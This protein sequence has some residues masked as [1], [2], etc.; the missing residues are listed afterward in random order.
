MPSSERGLPSEGETEAQTDTGLPQ[1]IQ[2]EHGSLGFALRPGCTKKRLGWQL[3]NLQTGPGPTGA[4][5]GSRTLPEV[6]LLGTDDVTR[7]KAKITE[8]Q[9]LVL[10]PVHAGGWVCS[11]PLCSCLLCV[12]ARTPMHA[13]TPHA[14]PMCMHFPCTCNSVGVPVSECGWHPA[15]VGAGMWVLGEAV[16]A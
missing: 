5:G 2:P 12:H 9:F 6:V 13:P 14:R 16:A 11:V 3:Q 10:W 8:P 15:R 4:R 1:V 7:V